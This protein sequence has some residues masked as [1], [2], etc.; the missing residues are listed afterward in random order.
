MRRTTVTTAATSAGLVAAAALFVAAPAIADS[1]TRVSG[2]VTSYAEQLPEADAPEGA[3]ARVQSVATGDG[4]TVV[5]LKVS[6]FEPFAQYGAH[7]HT[8]PCGDPGTDPK[9]LFAGPHFQHLIDPVAPSVDPA[10]AN[11][12]NEIWLDFATNRAG[13]GHA[14]AVVDWQFT[15]ERRAKSVII[16]ER[17]TSTEPGKH[18]MAGKRVACLNVPF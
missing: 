4:K 2:E 1:V 9:G 14:K 15:P 7:A 6:G 16:H 11:P 12:E 18:G 10:Y 8:K 3:T 13:E 17:R 5:T